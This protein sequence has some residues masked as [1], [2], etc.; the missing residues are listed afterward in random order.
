[1]QARLFRFVVHSMG[2]GRGR[3][4]YSI[5]LDLNIKL[6]LVDY[7]IKN[8]ELPSHLRTVMPLLDIQR[9]I[10]IVTLQILCHFTKV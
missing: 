6:S 2:R 3:V 4:V 10:K 7:F 5:I 1:M 9:Q 8:F